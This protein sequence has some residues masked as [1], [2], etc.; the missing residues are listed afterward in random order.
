MKPRH[1]DLSVEFLREYSIAALSNAKMLYS[2]AK[3]LLE[4]S[5]FA[6]AYFLSIATIEEIGKAVIA[7]DAQ[8]RKLTNT[9][10]AS[11][12]RSQLASHP[13]KINA[14]FLPWIL[15]SD[16]PKRDALLAASL[17]L[18]LSQ[19]R[20]ASIYVDVKPDGKSVQS[21]L[22]LVLENHAKSCALIIENTLPAAEEHISHGSPI[23]RTT[24]DDLFLTLSVDELK[25]IL[26][27]EPF[28]KYFE[29]EIAKGHINFVEIIAKYYKGYC[30]KSGK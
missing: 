9:R 20:E 4:R 6:R 18:D 15:S 21:P 2:E 13:A 16:D 23:I 24:A 26:S 5:Y 30:R 11:K 7:F 8:G 28:L 19:G 17:S 22:K 14:S 27:Q 1:F 3:L 10:V 12:I 25:Y 29:E